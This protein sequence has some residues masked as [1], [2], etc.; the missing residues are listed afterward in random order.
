MIRLT[1]AFI[2]QALP[3][4]AFARG[5]TVLAGG[6]AGA[7]LLLLL[8]APVL[9]RLYNPDDFGVFAIYISALALFGVISSLRYELAIPL[10]EDD[11]EAAN[12]TIL[13]LILVSISSIFTSILVLLLRQPIA[14]LLGISELSDF[15]WLLPISI[16]FSGAYNIFNYWCIRT[17]RFSSIAVTKT[18]Q[19]LVTIAIQLATFKLGNVGLI[20]GYVA[21]QGVGAK[22]L[23][24]P[25][26]VTEGFKQVSW[27]GIM[28]V[29]IRYRRFPIFSTL[30][31]FSNTAGLQIPPLMFA[32]LFTP[33]A[34]GIYALSNRVLNLP[35]SVLGNAIGQVFFASAVEA[36]RLGELGTLV[37]QLHSKLAH[38]GFP[39]ALLLLLLGP[40]LFA[41]VFGEVW[42]EAGD[43][44]RWMSPWLYLVFVTSPLS[45]LFVVIDRQGQGLV[46]Q[47]VLLTSRI[48][49]ITLGAW[50]GDFMLTIML[51]AVA[52][53]LCWLFFLFWT[54]YAVHT[55]PRA[56]IYPTVSAAG[57][58]LLC[59]SPV[60][61][62]IIFP[63]PF[64]NLWPYMLTLSLLM[65]IGRYW[66]FFKHTS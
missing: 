41:L 63:L 1:R 53:A 35:M 57:V 15:F 51:F 55:S 38:I 29:A 47:L 21:G 19:A 59:A 32:F 9:T 45:I 44:A 10:P 54:G 56:I 37:E 20:L 50:L 22:S 30:T 62:S 34:A 25:A 23:G 2:N 5:V 18:R 39:P 40:E 52:S 6:T 36:H 64:S 46:F 42:R 60:L 14:D 17:K 27:Q 3:R 11:S 7:Q 31:G 26:I 4:N 58:A 61:I 66:Q 33:A 43:F 48:I 24:Y 13:C 65:V 49:A 28:S 8:S 16:L 12:I